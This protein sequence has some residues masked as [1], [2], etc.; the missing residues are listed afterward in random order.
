M[1]KGK[2]IQTDAHIVTDQA[3]DDLF[4]NN[5]RWHERKTDIKGTA[6]G[7]RWMADVIGASQWGSHPKD[8]DVMYMRNAFLLAAEAMENLNHPN[9][10]S[11]E[12]TNHRK[13]IAKKLTDELGITSINKRPKISGKTVLSLFYTYTIEHG[14]GKM[15]AYKKI[16]TEYGLSS[17]RMVAEAVNEEWERSFHEY[18]MN[19]ELIT[20]KSS[21][22][23]DY[24]K[25]PVKYWRE[26]KEQSKSSDFQETPPDI[27]EYFKNS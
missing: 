10:D 17:Y 5:K 12:I 20:G 23:N 27:D 7:L 24:P 19:L 3:S 1:G 8:D 9:L 18:F 15:D 25:D 13:K 21:I 14:L 2:K 4:D 22:T 16:A 6:E 26:I 11:Y